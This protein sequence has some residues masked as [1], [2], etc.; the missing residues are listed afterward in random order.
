MLVVTDSKGTL[1]AIL[2][3]YACHCTTLGGE[4]NELCG[5]WAGYAQEFLER[6]HPGVTVLV[7]IGCGADANPQPRPG[8]NFDQQHGQE[9][10]TE[11]NRLLGITIHS[12]SRPATLSPSDGERDGVRGFR[13][14]IPIRGNLDCRAQEIEIPLDSPPTRAEF[15]ARANETNYVGYHARWTLA[16]L[17]RPDASA[18]PT[19]I[20]YL[21]QTW[22]FGDD[23]AM[24]FL[25]GEVVV[26]YALRLKKELDPDRTWVNAYANDVPCYIPSERIL[27]EGGY[28]GGGAMTY[29]GWPTRIAPGLEKLIV[30]T[31]HELLPKQFRFDEQQA[32]FPPPKSPEESLA[33][34]ETK[35]GLEVQLVASEPLVVDPV[36][37]DWSA[38]GKLWVVEM[39][40]YPSGLDGNWKPGGRVNIW[41]TRTATANTTRLRWWWM[42]SRFPRA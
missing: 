18:L 41:R 39:H 28:E 7:A 3:N 31:V 8:L 15:E 23:L 21:I 14:L 22:S 11:V 24:V 25:P 5:D 10:A 38:D 33:A 17:D 19:K 36:A 1:R 26:D 9:I 34:I 13:K 32:E 4:F 6:D 2:A 37:I 42:A 35:P 30:D 27:Q 20:P 40:D 12:P 16:K 29:Y